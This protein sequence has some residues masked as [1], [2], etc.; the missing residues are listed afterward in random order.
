M[1]DCVYIH[2]PSE[3]LNQQ[4]R[5]ENWRN[6]QGQIQPQWKQQQTRGINTTLEVNMWL[7]PQAL[8]KDEI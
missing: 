5:D 3:P 7:V 1:T 4:L 2:S 8:E 6:P